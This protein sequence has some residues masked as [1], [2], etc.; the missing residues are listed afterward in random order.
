MSEPTKHECERKLK[1]LAQKVGAE[2]TRIQWG[3][4]EHGIETIINLS[5]K[6]FGLWTK[7]VGITRREVYLAIQ[8]LNNGI[9]LVISSKLG[10]E[11]NLKAESDSAS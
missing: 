11:C 6:K 3:N 1:L 8:W 2:K 10:G 5:G 9:D 7:R 4:P